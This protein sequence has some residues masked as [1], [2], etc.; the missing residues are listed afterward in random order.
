MSK[1]NIE[2]EDRKL[3][4]ICQKWGMS[5]SNNEHITQLSIMDM[6]D[7]LLSHM[8]IVNRIP[9]EKDLKTLCLQVS[10]SGGVHGATDDHDHYYCECD[11]CGNTDRGYPSELVHKADCAVRIVKRIEKEY[12]E[13]FGCP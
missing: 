9:F 2:Y 5:I 6:Y 7:E 11:F 4:D 8:K 1:I 12:E 10:K 3:F 13:L